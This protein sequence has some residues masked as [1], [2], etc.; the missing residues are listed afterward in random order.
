[1]VDDDLSPISKTNK[2]PIFM[3]IKVQNTFCP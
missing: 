1:M 2:P 3:K